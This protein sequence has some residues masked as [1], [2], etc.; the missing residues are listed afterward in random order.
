MRATRRSIASQ[1]HVSLQGAVTSGERPKERRFSNRR[2]NQRA[3]GAWHEGVGREVCAR[4]NV[5]RAHRYDPRSP[6][7][8]PSADWWAG[9]WETAAPWVFR[10]STSHISSTLFVLLFLLLTVVV[11]AGDFEEGNELFDQGKFSEAKQHY[12]NIVESG[13]AGANVYYNLG[14]TDYRLGSAGRA[15]LDYERALALNP[16]HPEATANL[17]LLREQSASRI[18]PQPWVAT[19]FASQPLNTWMLAATAAGW[20]AILGLALFATGARLDNA[21]LWCLTLAGLV[22]L[23]F[24]GGGVWFGMKD[25]SLGIV[26][27]KEAEARLAPADSAGVAGTLTAGSRVH[28]LSE[29]GPWT[30]CEMPDASRGWV[31]QDMVE[32]VRPNRS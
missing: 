26:T 3:G 1:V 17:R 5:D 7:L 10:R 6:R 20:V 2:P 28:V 8:A 23:A 11:R 18:A 27:A 13:Q 21:G 32:R 16:R 29:R 4:G 12:E 25:Q 9:G 14:N 31:R 24:T 15:I 30:Y 22:A 19:V